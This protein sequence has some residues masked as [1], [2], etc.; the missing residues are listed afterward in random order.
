MEVCGTHTQAFRRFG[1]NSLL[2]GN[3]RLISGPGCPVCVSS[4]EFIDQ[5]IELA[6][7][8]DTI[9]LTFGDMLKVPGANSSLEQERAEGHDIR[10][11]YSP[12]ASLKIAEDNPKKRV[13]FLG[14]GFET[15]SPTIGLTIKAADKAKI[16]NLY[17]LTS[18]KLI[19]PAMK[20]LLKDKRLRIDGFICPGH[21]SA[22]IGTKPYAF[23]PESY[24]I[25]CCVTGF[26]P[27]DMLEGIGILL[28][29]I[30]AKKRKVSN[31]YRR[32]V[33]PEGNRS[34][35][36]VLKDVFVISDVNWRG[37][38]VIPKSGLKINSRFIRFDARKILIKT[39][40]KRTKP[41]EKG[42][43]CGDI[44]KGLILPKD[45]PLF[46]KRCLPNKPIGPCMVSSE[47][48]CNA[49]YRYR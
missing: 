13:I 40:P 12:L 37:L 14:V 34:A 31:Q 4:S 35:K 21:V 2:P 41:P 22:V 16:K 9:I 19:P 44:L 15:T 49:H 11:L 1:L 8:N 23:I 20:A 17:F 33:K 25:N 43:C 32:V 26:E 6:K 46:G 47:G 42:C 24:K 28:K 36:A 10:I 48:A 39:K 18:L 29:D 38:G 5:A 27:L 3:I 7:Q 45:C 30:N